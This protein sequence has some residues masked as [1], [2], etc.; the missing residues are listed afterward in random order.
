[1]TGT[2]YDCGSDAGV[3]EALRATAAHRP[4]AP[5]KPLRGDTL[6]EMLQFVDLYTFPNLLQVS[7]EMKAC[8][9]DYNRRFAEGR[10]AVIPYVGP[11]NLYF[12][13]EDDDITE[14]LLNN[15]RVYAHYEQSN[16]TELMQRG[17]HHVPCNANNSCRALCWERKPGM[18]HLVEDR[19]SFQLSVYCEWPGFQ[20]F[21]RFDAEAPESVMTKMWIDC[22]S[23]EVGIHEVTS[24]R[25][26]RLKY[27]VLAREKGL[28]LG[29]EDAYS[30]DFRILQFSMTDESWAFLERRYQEEKLACEDRHRQEQHRRNLVSDDPAVRMAAEAIEPRPRS[31]PS[32]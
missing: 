6:K 1:M 17:Y 18:S 11:E 30:C 16:R 5:G 19:G 14:T 9:P 27:E 29:Q 25:G 7:R 28:F 12:V 13:S 10:F 4:H 26:M 32:S 23:T 21:M 24:E 31:P 2:K 15:E 20:V 8:V 22:P 3:A